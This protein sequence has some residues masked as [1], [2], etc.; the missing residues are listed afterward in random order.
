SGAGDAFTAA[1]T[2]AAAAGVPWPQAVA[3][4][5]AAADVVVAE[6]GPTTCDT[7]ALAAHLGG[8]PG[9]V[10]GLPELEAAVAAHRAAGR[11]IVFSNGCFDVL[12]R[13]HVACLEE[14]RRLG[15]VLIVAVNSDAGVRRLKGPG[16]PVNPAEDR[17]AV[18][19]A[20]ACVD[21]TT[22]FD[23]DTPA[24]LLRRLRPDVYVKGGD[25]TPQMLAE[26]PVVESYGGQVRIVRYVPGHSTTA[27]IERILAHHPAGPGPSAVPAGPG[28]STGQ[29]PSGAGP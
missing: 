21:H 6:P 22:V 7:A 2:L 8:W 4:G 25:Y 13:A 3:L 28:P 16:R 19:A 5:Q 24:E 12:H 26:T 23:E 10:I 17:A 27:V 18:L 9:E 14:A 20:L 1:T 11:R 15:D 29:Q